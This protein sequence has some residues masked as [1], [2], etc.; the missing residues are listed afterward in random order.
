M[1]FTFTTLAIAGSLVSAAALLW[2]V[3]NLANRRQTA[4]VSGQPAP[5]FHAPD[6]APMQRLL[7]EADFEFLRS[8]PGFQPGLETRLRRERRAIFN[9]YLRRLE[10][11]Y[12]SMSAA[13]Q[14]LIVSAP[15]DQSALLAEVARQ[16]FRF[17]LGLWRVR[18]GVALHGLH[19][20][21][22]PVHVDRLV[23]A[24]DRLS[25]IIRSLNQPAPA[26]GF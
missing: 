15:Q 4:R 5:K 12:R 23:E 7:N 1:E 22:P 25:G 11:D 26:A 24:A 9:L 6:Y 20:A 10:R 17:R 19:L 3:R 16:N 2:V 14:A 18:V 13:L 21:P 8:Q